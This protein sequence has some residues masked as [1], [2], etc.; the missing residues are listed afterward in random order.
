MG[1][2]LMEV[3]ECDQSTMCKYTHNGCQIIK[4]CV[5]D[6]VSLTTRPPAQQSL[7]PHFSAIKFNL[8]PQINNTNRT[9]MSIIFCQS[10]QM[11]PRQ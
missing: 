3:E 1:R 6:D 10:S 9:Y 7:N 2:K 11:H 8:T 5:E 4:V